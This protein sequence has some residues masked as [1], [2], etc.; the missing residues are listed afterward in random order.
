MFLSL[1]LIFTLAFVYF[2]LY[3]H[4]VDYDG[5]F[6]YQVELVRSFFSFFFLS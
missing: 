4:S 2:A 3:A 1:L 5:L 6:F